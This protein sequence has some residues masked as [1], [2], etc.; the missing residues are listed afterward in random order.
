MS[1]IETY[2]QFQ[3]LKRSGKKSVARQM[4][5]KL[6]QDYKE[7]PDADFIY[8]IC[9]LCDHKIDFIVW[10]AI[11]LPELKVRLWSDPKAIKAL[12][13]TIQNLYSSTSDWASLDYVTEEQL[14]YRLLELDPHDAWAKRQ[15]V[16]QLK[17][18]LQYTVHEWPSGILYGTDGATLEQCDEIIDAVNE[19]R[20]LD[21]VQSIELCDEVVKKTSIYKSKL[22]S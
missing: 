1:L 9:E 13:Q 7:T 15:R 21:P 8:A 3:E 22:N 19:L 12:M 5:D 2:K 16:E 14:V 18:W 10:K 4:A 11:V 20:E 6:I 17:N